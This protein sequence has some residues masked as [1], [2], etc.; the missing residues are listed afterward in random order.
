ML[1]RSSASVHKLWRRLYLEIWT[2]SRYIAFFEVAYC[3]MFTTVDPLINF[4]WLH[5]FDLSKVIRI[6]LIRDLSCLNLSFIEFRTHALSANLIG[7]FIFCALTISHL[8]ISVTH[9]RVLN[10]LS[11]THIGLR[12]HCWLV[13]FRSNRGGWWLS[14]CRANTSLV[15]VHIVQAVLVAENSWWVFSGIN[16]SISR[17][18]LGTSWLHFCF[19]YDHTILVDLGLHLLSLNILLVQYFAWFWIIEP[20][21]LKYLCNRH[22]ILL[23]FL[24]YFLGLLRDNLDRFSTRWL[25]WIIRII[26]DSIIIDYFSIMRNLIL[27]VL[28]RGGLDSTWDLSIVII[29]LVLANHVRVWMLY[30]ANLAAMSNS[31]CAACVLNHF[32]VLFWVFS[33]LRHKSWSWWL[34]TFSL[35]I[36]KTSDLIRL[37]I[38][39][40]TMIIHRQIRV[41]FS[42]VRVQRLDGVLIWRILSCVILWLLVHLLSHTCSIF[43]LLLLHAEC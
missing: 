21:L 43:E 36:L 30:Y 5:L 2:S 17:S 39:S 32:L 12:S 34:L 28:R 4:A 6:L 22:I 7:T 20:L 26:W 3:L 38:V 27:R 35:L 13:S 31:I 33:I 29:K 16:S 10:L 40:P 8:N 37:K 1:I 24:T 25:I 18:S 11:M 15:L 42:L 23:R 14:P 41:D 19:P 9:L